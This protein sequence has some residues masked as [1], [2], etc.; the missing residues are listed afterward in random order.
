MSAMTWP[1]PAHEV[2]S[3]P[4][5]ELAMRLLRHLAETPAGHNEVNRTNTTGNLPREISREIAEAYD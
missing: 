5:D 4:V 1:P 3:L 2:K